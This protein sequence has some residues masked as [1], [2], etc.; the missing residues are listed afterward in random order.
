M[1]AAVYVS[2]SGSSLCSVINPALPPATCFARTGSARGS[3]MGSGS[4][5]V[6]GAEESE[7]GRLAPGRFPHTEEGGERGY[8]EEPRPVQV[9][10]VAWALAGGQAE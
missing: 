5:G 9:G 6:I 2:N 3:G 4:S 7:F 8:K 10:N 1:G